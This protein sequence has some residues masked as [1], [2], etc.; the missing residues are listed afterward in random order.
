[1][2]STGSKHDE[3]HAP[4]LGWTLPRVEH[5]PAPCC[6]LRRSGLVRV[7]PSKQPL[8]PDARPTHERPPLDIGR[9]ANYYSG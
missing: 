1:M 5:A 3:H 6:P 7:D 2:E 8:V 9:A 4:A